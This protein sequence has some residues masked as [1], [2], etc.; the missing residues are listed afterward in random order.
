[1]GEGAGGLGG[2]VGGGGQA[3]DLVD[4]AA[5]DGGGGGGISDRGVGA[6]EDGEQVVLALV[7]AAERVH[8]L[9]RL[10]RAREPVGRGALREVGV[11]DRGERVGAHRRHLGGRGLGATRALE[12]LARPAECEQRARLVDDRAGA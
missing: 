8:Q 11:G 12:R 3:L 10:A 5:R 6:R 7:D 1:G 2:V 9:D 4:R